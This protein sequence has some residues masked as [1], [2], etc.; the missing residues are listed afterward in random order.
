[1]EE[2][3][4]PVFEVD[5]CFSSYAMDYSLVGAENISDLKEHLNDIFGDSLSKPQIKKIKHPGQGD[6]SRIK[7]IDGLYTKEPYKILTTYGYAE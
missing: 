4:Y 3:I 7:K 2:K 5:T 6:F 1:M